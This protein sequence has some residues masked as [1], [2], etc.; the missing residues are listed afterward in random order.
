MNNQTL[1]Q[2]EF[3]Q[4]QS[5]IFKEAGISMADSKLP[6]VAGRLGKRIKHYEMA[7]FGEYFKFIHAPQN[8]SEKQIA[9][10]LLTTNETHFFREPKHFDYLRDV[11]LPNRPKGRSF[12]VWSAAS[13][14]GEE[15]YTLA[16]V[17]SEH[18]P[19]NSWELIG[20]DISTAVL[21]KA[22]AGS[23][24]MQ[25][26]EEIPKHYLSKYCMKGIGT[27]EG[28]MLVNKEL[29]Q[30][31]SFMA[32]NLIEPYPE[33]GQFDVIFL[34]NVMI[35][36]NNDTK[37]DIVRKMHEK[38]R[39]GGFLFISHSESLNGIADYLE[40]VQPSVYKKPL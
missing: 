32:M 26:A 37:K 3:S 28:T 7:S 40:V 30:H 16:M 33:I 24:P 14:S 5:F 13:S 9:I 27:A 39:P 19:A 12:R 36:F 15:V 34:R 11:I 8:Q 22:K 6:L 21:E 23:Y 25:R 4:F 29:R 35:Y 2:K 31:V 20:S 18:L 1:T 17:L 38:L 10:N